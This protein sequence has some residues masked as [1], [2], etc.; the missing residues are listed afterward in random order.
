MLSVFPESARK[1]ES[2]NRPRFPPFFCPPSLGVSGATVLLPF[3]GVLL[4]SSLFSSATTVASIPNP[5]GAWSPYLSSMSVWPANDEDGSTS[6]SSDTALDISP[7]ADDEKDSLPVAASLSPSLFRAQRW[8]TPH[9]NRRTPLAHSSLPVHDDGLGASWVALTEDRNE[10]SG[11]EEEG[12]NKEGESDKAESE[13]EKSSVSENDSKNEEKTE[14]K[15]SET[16]DEA[17][18]RSE[19]RDEQDGE[20]NKPGKQAQAAPEEGENASA[21]SEK[22]SCPRACLIASKSG[23][24]TGTDGHEKTNE[25]RADQKGGE[26]ASTTQHEEGQETEQGSEEANSS[27]SSA[28][29]QSHETPVAEH[30]PC[31]HAEE[32]NATNGS[33]SAEAASEDSNPHEA[34]KHTD[35]HGQT[36]ASDQAQGHDQE[37]ASQSSETPAEENAEEPKQAEEQANASQSSET[38]AEENAEEP[39]QAEE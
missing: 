11:A 6:V 16:G 23:G 7:F 25:V 22:L 17:A 3:V 37:E 4:F 24:K 19:D 15:D 26:G 2:V 34:V 29:A 9:N 31:P 38:P 33:N 20:T 1:M 12:E 28:P 8:Q 32:H 18:A 21:S 39:K 10:G 5:A 27:S 36:Q 14:S 30:A 13:E 35:A